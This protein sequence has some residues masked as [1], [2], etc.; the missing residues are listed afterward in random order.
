[1]AGLQSAFL[2][3]RLLEI[4]QSFQQKYQNPAATPDGAGICDDTI[5]VKLCSIH[6]GKELEL[7][8]ETCEELTCLRCA[9]K[10]GKHQKHDYGEIDRAFATYKV[11]ISLLIE[12]MEKQLTTIKKALTDLDA[13]CEEIS[14]QRATVESSIR[15]TCSEYSDSPNDSKVAELIDQLHKV[16]QE[17]LKSL[18]AQRDQ[19]ETIQAQLSSCLHFMK[20]SLK[21]GNEGDVLMTKKHT[22][23]QANLLT[24]PLQ[25]DLLEPSADAN[26]KFLTSPG[27]KTG[28]LVVSSD[29]DPVKSHVTG[30]GEQAIEVGRSA[31]VTLHAIN[32]K[33]QSCMELLES[34]IECELISEMT[35][36]RTSCSV[37][38]KGR[39]QYEISY[40]PTIKGRHQL[41]I[42]AKGQHIRGSP[43][44]IAAHSPVEVLGGTNLRLLAYTILWIH[45][46]WRPSGV[47]VNRRGQVFV[48]EKEGHCVSMFSPSGKRLRLFGSGGSGVG[49]LY[50]P[51]GIAVDEED[52]ILVVDSGNNRVQKF[53]LE[54]KF[55]A[56][57][58]TKGSGALTLS[59]P[60]D[61]AFNT[62]NKK[63]YVADSGNHRVQVLNSD[64]T[65]FNTFGESGS[66]KGQ[67]R[68][69]DGIACD[70]TG[71]VYVS[72]FKNGGRIQIFTPEGEFLKQ[73]SAKTTGPIAID[74][75][76]QLYVGYFGSVSVFSSEGRLVT[77]FGRG[78][79]E[80][81]TGLAVDCNGVVYVCDKTNN[82]VGV[83]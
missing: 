53:T 6:E 39:N 1:M 65:Y 35:G 47:A 26:I 79:S 83:F 46:L 57:F 71:K 74:S 3:N 14:D 28:K 27:N 32:F 7:Y 13:R 11:E 72:D 12:P 16:T 8:C 49:Q 25:Q 68:D 41:H 34:S 37:G 30:I 73:Y 40:R 36:T 77:I 10:G 18:A 59:A 52:N 23:K 20:E 61:I 62:S 42:K 76:D 43:F 75:N 21:T 19:I 48:T 69:L 2:I 4:E 70:N 22:I 64:L 80:H 15:T 81:P 50:F 60:T 82:C 29:L 66:G 58:S 38:Q 63:V 17:K 67:F 56:Y 55:L 5:K 24:A 51:S 33:G 9:L 45:G 31:S 78:N 54:E 44:D